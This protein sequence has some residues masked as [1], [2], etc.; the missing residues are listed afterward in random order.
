MANTIGSVTASSP[1]TISLVVSW[2]TGVPTE[3]VYLDMSL[4]TITGSVS[5]VRSPIGFTVNTFSNYDLI[6]TGLLEGETITLDADAAAIDCGVGLP[7]YTFTTVAL[8]AEAVTNN[9]TTGRPR[10]R[11]RERNFIA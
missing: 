3:F 10:E 5:G 6:T 7:S 11:S 2:D 1:T 9:I 8:V 4:F